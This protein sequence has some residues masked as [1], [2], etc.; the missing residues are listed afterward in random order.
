MVGLYH[1]HMNV[2]LQRPKY[3]QTAMSMIESQVA[4]DPQTLNDFYILLNQLRDKYPAPCQNQTQAT[5]DNKPRKD[6]NYVGDKYL[7][8]LFGVEGMNLYDELIASIT[9]RVRNSASL[10]M[11]SMKSSKPSNVLK[12]VGRSC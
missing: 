10:M 4:N 7:G 12:K 9:R 1:Y 2:I 11:K 6:V 8:G 3:K 5:F